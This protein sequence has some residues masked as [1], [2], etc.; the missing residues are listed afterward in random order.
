MQSVLTKYKTARSFRLMVSKTKH[1]SMNIVPVLLAT[2]PVTLNIQLYFVGVG[3]HA[4]GLPLRRLGQTQHDP[5][6]DPADKE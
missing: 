3:S 1:K 2:F 6:A 5:A 4:S